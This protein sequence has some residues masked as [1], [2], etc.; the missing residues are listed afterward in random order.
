[1]PRFAA[2]VSTLYPELALIDRIGAAARDGFAAVEVQGPYAVQAQDF[3][4]ALDDARVQLVLMN[5]PQGHSDAGERGLAALPGREQDFESAMEQA[6]DY[7]R[8]LG[9]P[10]LHVMAGKPGAAPAEDCLETYLRNLAYACDLVHPHGITVTIEPINQRD[11]PGY[12]LSRQ[13]QAADV[14]AALKKPNL[15]LQMDFYHLQIMEGDLVRHLERYFPLVS[16]V[17]IAGVPERSEPDTGEVHYP[18]IFALL[19]RLR[20]AGWVGCEYRPAR[21]GAGG[22]SAGLGWLRKI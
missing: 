22:T 10:R 3:R 16:H 4:R 7:A 18:L 11:V 8:I 12:Y 6:M 5:A 9:A 2:N 14:I 1:M 20:Y 15:G 13:Q 19:D 17:Q 21:A